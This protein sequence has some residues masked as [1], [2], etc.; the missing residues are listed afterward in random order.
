MENV[1]LVVHLIACISM[2]GVIML[3]RSEGGVQGLSGGGTGGLISGRGAASVLV[4]TTMICAGIF[5]ITSLAMTN[6]NNQESSQPNAVQQEIDRQNQLNRGILNAPGPAPAAI[7]TLDPNALATSDLLNP[8][9]P[10]NPLAPA[11][12]P[13]AAAPA[14]SPAASPSARASSPAPAAPAPASPTAP[15]Q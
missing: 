3:Q 9:A 4:R 6:L 12:S 5:F 10:S 1:L 13:S 8:L 7:P 2:V 11:A 15:P 14:P